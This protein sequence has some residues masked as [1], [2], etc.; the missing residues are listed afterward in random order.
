LILSKLHP[1][2]HDAFGIVSTIA[3]SFASRRP[4]G[5][6]L[7]GT[8]KDFLKSS[9]LADADDGWLAHAMTRAEQ[10][11]RFVHAESNR[12]LLPG[13]LLLDEIRWDTCTAGH[14]DTF[15]EEDDE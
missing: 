3:A 13:R 2:I 6:T 11:R 12:T 7:E 4:S 9:I 10:L 15:V 14:D 5:V 8:S 1:C